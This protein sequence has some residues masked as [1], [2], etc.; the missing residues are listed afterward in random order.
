MFFG[1]FRVKIKVGRR[2]IH[3]YE[4]GTKKTR[5]KSIETTPERNNLLNEKVDALM[6]QA[7]TAGSS[8]PL[9]ACLWLGS[10]LYLYISLILWGG[11]GVVF[12]LAE[13]IFFLFTQEIS[14]LILLTQNQFYKKL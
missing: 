8:Y 4:N 2:Y 3:V 1:F 13:V 7:T 9:F 11:G 14:A 5:I 12:H 10:G 6:L